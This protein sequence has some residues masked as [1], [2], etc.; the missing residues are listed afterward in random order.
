MLFRS[1]RSRLTLSF[2]GIALIA[3]L[4]LGAVL[5]A[6][7]QNYYSNQELDYLR[8]NAQSIGRVVAAMISGSASHD[9]MQ[10][11]IE[12]LAFLSQTRVEIYAPDGQLLYDSGSPQNL[13]V[14]LGT[15]KQLALEIN[16]GPPIDALPII[17]IVRQGSSQSAAAPPPDTSAVQVM[18]DG[19]TPVQDPKGFFL[20]QSIQTGSSPFGYYLNTVIPMG[21]SRSNLKITELIRNPQSN[22]ELGS[23][24]LSEGPAYGTAILKSVAEGWALASIIAI[25]LA[26][27][28]GLYISQ[29]ISAPILGLT[30]VT[31]QMA[32]GNLSSRAE[33]ENRDELGQLSR[34]FNKMADQIET[35]VSA[36]RQFVSDAAHELRTPLTALRTNLDL[37][38]D[39]NN[40]E[41]RAV[42]ISRARA[43]VQRLEELD[44][45]LLDLSRLEA[46]GYPAGG[47][48]LDLK[49]LLEQRSE[50]YASQAEQADLAL[51]VELPAAPAQV[52]ADPDQVR[53]A[54]DN[55]MDNACKFTPQGGTVRLAVRREDGQVVFSVTDTGIGI[56]ADELSQIFNRFHRGRNSTP[57]PGS[58]LGLA[59]VKAIVAVYGGSVEGQSLGEGRGSRF[60]IKLPEYNESGNK[61]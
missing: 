49:A 48:I 4:A 55:L 3:A 59:I 15:G 57:Y 1:I 41:A 25:L 23:V 52:R 42:Y 29:R 11:Q 35:T 33:I 17:S 9:E 38:L 2:A 54:M 20:Y 14:N 28:V 44:T 5:L 45:N 27:A 19:S 39:E 8:G 26:A 21:V 16:G 50:F 37:A 46:A 22:A 30:A 60:A 56:P 7:L 61:Q 34:S 43:M 51:E 53:R 31:T 18:L 32:R 36:L 6:I 40:A 58:G 13:D 47:T 24:V 10:S 12:N